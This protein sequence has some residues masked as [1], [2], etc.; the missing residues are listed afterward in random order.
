MIDIVQEKLRLLDVFRQK[1]ADK[2]FELA[3]RMT[4]QL[5]EERK[6]RHKIEQRREEDE[7][8]LEEAIATTA[9]VATFN[10]HLDEYDT[11]TVHALMDNQHALDLVFKQRQE[12]EAAAF[13]LPDGRMVFR[14]EDGQRVFDQHG[15]AL[16]SETIHPSSIPSSAPTW[17]S[18]QSMKAA[19][20]KLLHERD[21]LHNYQKSVDEAR[22]EAAKGNV[23]AGALTRMEATLQ[24]TMPD[25]VRSQLPGSTA[26][27]DDSNL[28]YVPPAAPA[29]FDARLYAPAPAGP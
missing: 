1:A 3:M 18:E 4:D 8:K 24:K 21:Q 14:T 9:Q 5:D 15:A 29:P 20:R 13:R 23:T 17:E 7:R 2:R 25:A 11:A 26:E 12:M 27:R 22:E 16:G 10:E 19:E 28:R 6:Q